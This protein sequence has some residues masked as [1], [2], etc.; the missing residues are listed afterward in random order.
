VPQL[1]VFSGAS[2]FDNPK[3]FPWT[4]P[5][6]SFYDTEAE[7]FANYILKNMPNA[8]I[9]VLYQAD[10][11]GKDY[12]KGLHSGL[13][14][15]AATMIVKEVSNQIT[16]PTIDSQILLLKESGADTIFFATS[17]KFGAQAIRK[18]NE[19]GWKPQLLLTAPINSVASVLTPGGLEAS[20]GA[21]TM[22]D[23]KLPNDPA[24][25]NDKGMQDYMAFMKENFPTIDPSDTLP[26]YGYGAGEILVEIL[27]RSG[28]NLTRENLLKQATNLKG[29]KVSVLL[30]GI[31]IQT[32]PQSY[33]TIEQQQFAKFDGK[34]WVMFGDVVGRPTTAAK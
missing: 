34:K 14:D 7:A 5:Y 17:V 22:M 24:L 13:G 28:D 30:P 11:I 32:N 10:D 19:L 16:D 3:E 15:K 4:T 2:R 33:A 9:G 18:I 1:L 8:K 25:A 27:R 20:T 12:L 6:P 31:T 26:L 21:I 23:F 29:L